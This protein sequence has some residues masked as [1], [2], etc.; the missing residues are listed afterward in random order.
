[1]FIHQ[2][3]IHKTKKELYFQGVSDYYQLTFSAQ[4]FGEIRQSL[5]LCGVHVDVFS[6]TDVFIIDNVVVNS[7]GPCR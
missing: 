5:P 4:P 6:V 7:F 2:Y 1:M 3:I